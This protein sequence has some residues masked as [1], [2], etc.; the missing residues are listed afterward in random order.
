VVPVMLAMT[1]ASG[2]TAFDALCVAAGE[3]RISGMSMPPTKPTVPVSEAIA[4]I[5][6][7]R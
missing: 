4:A 6:P 7:T 5:M 3:A 1:V 2:F